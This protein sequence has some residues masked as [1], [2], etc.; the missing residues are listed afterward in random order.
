MARFNA[1][2]PFDWRLWDA[3]ITGSVAWATAIWRAGLLT[4]DERDQIIRGLEAVRD[5][6]AADPAAAF[7]DAADEDIHSFIE[8]RL[9]ERIG[10]VAG[11]LH[12]GRS[13]NDQV[14]AALRLHAREQLVHL[15]DAVAHVARQLLELAAR[16]RETSMPGY[17]HT[18]QAMPSTL[19]L[20]LSA[21]AE[22]LLSAVPGCRW[23]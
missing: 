16:H 9:T 13:R 6:I 19:G 23:R 17:T 7:V 2:L 22:G 18:R 12:T 1:S 5:E 10:A 14:I 4:E 21:H 15:V 3:D 20:V 11:K 8:R